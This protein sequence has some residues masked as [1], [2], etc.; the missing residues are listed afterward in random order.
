MKSWVIGVDVAC[1]TGSSCC[2]GTRNACRQQLHCILLR[3]D[4]HVLDAAVV[5]RQA[6]GARSTVSSESMLVWCAG[7]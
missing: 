1:S 4:L 3:Y 2:M 5:Y 7:G 6:P